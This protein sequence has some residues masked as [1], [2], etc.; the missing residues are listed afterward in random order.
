MMKNWLSKFKLV[1]LVGIGI[2]FLVLASAVF[3]LLRKAT[4]VVIVVKI[5]QEYSQDKNT[6]SQW[7][8]DKI[9]P[10]T[11][12]KGLTG[13]TD[14]S[15]VDVVSQYSSQNLRNYYVTLRLLTSFDRKNNNYVY[16]GVPIYTGGYQTFRINEIQIEGEVVRVGDVVE[17]SQLKR[18][19]VDLEVNPNLIP[20]QDP[21]LGETFTNGIY[22]YL[23]AKFVKGQ[24]ILDGSGNEVAV[25]K[26]VVVEPATRKFNDGNRLAEVIDS[27]RKKVKLKVEMIG[28][29]YGDVYLFRQLVPIKVNNVVY[30][31]FWDFGANAIITDFKEI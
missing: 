17:S 13:K 29:K 18:F 5:N 2:F 12:Q 30:L 16:Q 28:E 31:D 3:F 23:V 4:Y 15:V 24:K 1:D 27:D 25:I 11:E 19:L 6:T 9:K 26:E 20:N 8:L 22:N 10:G 7:Y 14:I 21:N